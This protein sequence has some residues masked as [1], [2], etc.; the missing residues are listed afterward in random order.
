[1]THITTIK[2][3]DNTSCNLLQTRHSFTPLFVENAKQTCRFFVPCLVFC[4]YWGFFF[5]FLTPKLHL[6]AYLKSCRTGCPLKKHFQQYFCFTN[7]TCQD[8]LERKSIFFKICASSIQ[9]WYW[10]LSG[11]EGAQNT[12]Q[13]LV[14]LFCLYDQNKY[15]VQV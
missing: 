9:L 5:A 1:M 10:Q 8:T 7:C 6:S 13:T 14:N 12:S 2:N 11:T 4:L 15:L 3:K